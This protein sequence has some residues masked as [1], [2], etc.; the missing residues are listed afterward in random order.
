MVKFWFRHF[1]AFGMDHINNNKVKDL[2]VIIRYHFGSEKLKGIPKKVEPVNA[3]KYFLESIGM[4][5]RRYGGMGCLLKQI[6]LFMKLVKRWEKDL[7]F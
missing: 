3:V 7:Y 6:M 4:V 2:R 5:F 1:L